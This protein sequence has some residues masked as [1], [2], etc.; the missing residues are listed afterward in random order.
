MT[1]SLYVRVVITFLG[2]VMFS[3]VLGA[4]ING[5]LFTKQLRDY[6]QDNLISSG[7]TIIQA[8]TESYPNNLDAT[9]KGVT[10]F[11]NYSIRLYGEDGEL[12]HADSMPE[13]KPFAVSPERVRDVLKGSVLSDSNWRSNEDLAVGLPF[14]IEGHSFALFLSVNYD[15]FGEM[16]GKVLRNQLF[17]VLLIGS[18][19]IAVAA[20]YV[21]RPLQRLTRATRQ[22]ARGDFNIRF[23]SKRKDEI[24][25]LTTSFNSM[26]EELGALERVRRQFV[27]DVSHEIQSPLTSI[28][29]FAQA[30]MHKKLDEEDRMRLLGII[31]EESNRLS[32]LSEDLLQLSSLEYEHQQLKIG[33]YRLDE[34]LR[35]VIIASEPQWAAKNVNLSL[36][37]P[38]IKVS[39]D[40]DKLSQLWTNLIGNSVKFAP[41]GGEVR[42][43]IEADHERV[44]VSIA[45]NGP[46]I[47][48]EDLP[49]IFRPF[50]KA[51]KARGGE[52]RGNGIGLSI[53]RRI[54]DLHQG[55]IQVVSRV[56]EGTT[57]I[58]TLPLAPPR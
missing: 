37:S 48:E 53:V 7:R 25:Q 2:A 28:K 32:R 39:A 19:F 44:R 12:L 20:R 33:H 13:R 45:D 15:D 23:R 24:G 55:D 26:A 50:Y 9:M 17:I 30:L 34:Q 36:D 52:H 1:K 41:E 49:H 47:P 56:G 29:G 35:H 42:V 4:I 14:N 31:N 38:E 43:D 18:V 54:V 51:D 58:V 40:A 16:I 11:P 3:M 10:A 27:S 57:L 46:G 8:Y 5:Q 21:V 6:M 22:M